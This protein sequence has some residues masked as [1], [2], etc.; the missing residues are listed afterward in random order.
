MRKRERERER[1]SEK[2]RK[3]ERNR[4]RKTWE[5]EIIKLELQSA[6]KQQIFCVCSI[7]WRAVWTQ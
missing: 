4:Q 2:T 7:I 5:S 3:T 1:E 6:T